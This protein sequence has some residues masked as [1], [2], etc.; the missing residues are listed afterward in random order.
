MVIGCRFAGTALTA[1]IIVATG[2]SDRRL[3][4]R[5]WIIVVRLRKSLAA[6]HVYCFHIG[7]T[8]DNHLAAAIFI[9]LV[10]IVL[11]LDHRNLL[12]WFFLLL[13]VR[14][15]W[16]EQLGQV[17][18][19]KLLFVLKLDYGNTL[20][21]L[22]FKLLGIV[23]HY[24]TSHVAR[25][26]SSRSLGGAYPSWAGS[27]CLEILEIKLRCWIVV[28]SGVSR[29]GCRWLL[30]FLHFFWMHL[31]LF[32]V[33]IDQAWVS[34]FHALRHFF[35]LTLIA[36]IFLQRWHNDLCSTILISDKKDSTVTL[37]D[38]DLILTLTLRP[39]SRLLR[40]RGET[41]KTC[42]EFIDFFLFIVLDLIFFIL[43][44]FRGQLAADNAQLLLLVF[45]TIW[46]IFLIVFIT[47]FTS[48]TTIV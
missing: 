7:A 23:F 33:I 10:I 3:D 1:S 46:N 41:F 38:N 4:V 48:L 40:G 36:A 11:H 12:R 22:L 34:L 47:S 32:I 31:L 16:S 2:H 9:G 27:G 8:I 18:M 42:C 17:R 24:D 25:T 29:G 13:S 5:G 35:N 45:T 26:G 39:L 20:L 30:K 19:G 37:R 6:S 44:R 15:T 21:L 14:P 28:R 43:V